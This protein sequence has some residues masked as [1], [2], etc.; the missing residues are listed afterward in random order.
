M[1]TLVSSPKQHL[2]KD[3]QHSVYEVCDSKS[4][5]PALKYCFEGTPLRYSAIACIMGLTNLAQ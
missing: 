5:K 3:M 4:E 2:S 1:I